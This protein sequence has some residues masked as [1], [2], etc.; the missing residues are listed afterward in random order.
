MQ[1]GDVSYLAPEYKAILDQAAAAQGGGGGGAG[2][3]RAGAAPAA[4]GGA[5]F[6][7]GAEDAGSGAG[8]G[9]GPV[10]QEGGA[11]RG[12]GGTSAHE[13]AAAEEA[14]RQLFRDHCRLGG[15]G[16]GG[17]GVGSVKARI[18]GLDALL[19]KAGDAGAGLGEVVAYMRGG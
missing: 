4:I 14:I 7:A 3:F 8:G 16:G 12:V 19:Q 13:L 10:A 18:A 2:S 9:L 1:D 15:G 11:G 17:G 5:C 6:G